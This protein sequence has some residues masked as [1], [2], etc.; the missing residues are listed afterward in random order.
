[1]DYTKDDLALVSILIARIQGTPEGSAEIL[2]AYVDSAL[3]EREA[4]V[5]AEE[6]E[7]C[8]DVLKRAWGAGLSVDIVGQVFE[9]KEELKQ[10]REK[11]AGLVEAYEKLIKAYEQEGGDDFLMDANTQQ[12]R[13]ALATYNDKR[14]G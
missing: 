14:K 2:R 3:A 4:Q 7:N 6:R 1:M 10:E 11:V 13:G 12:A 8:D 5:R 9:L